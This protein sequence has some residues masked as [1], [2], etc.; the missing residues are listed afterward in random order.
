MKEILLFI[1][2]LEKEKKEVL[3]F[4]IK[5]C[6]ADFN[7]QNED[8]E[9]PSDLATDLGETDIVNF[10]S[11]SFSKPNTV[12]APEY[13]LYFDEETNLQLGSRKEYYPLSPQT[14]HYFTTSVVAATY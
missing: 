4:L 6:G 3:E 8:G 2:L 12:E 11:R 9:T 13:R 10:I 5:N 14:Q 7:L 1:M